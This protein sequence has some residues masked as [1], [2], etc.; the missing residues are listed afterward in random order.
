MEYEQGE[1]TILK[2][3]SGTQDIQKTNKTY[4]MILKVKALIITLGVM[5]GGTTLVYGLLNHTK[6]II[7]V[8]M[9][10]LGLVGAKLIYKEALDYLQDQEKIKNSK[11]N[12]KS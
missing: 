1:E 6:L 12:K 2:Q 3:G 11:W 9:A 5:I 4:N 8:A 10:I 7:T